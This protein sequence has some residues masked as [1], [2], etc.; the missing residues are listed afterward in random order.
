VVKSRV[1]EEVREVVNAVLL[2]KVEGFL[3][4]RWG[5]GSGFGGVLSACGQRRVIF[6]KVEGLLEVVDQSVK[7]RH[8]GGV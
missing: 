8:F 6:E 1:C 3:V 4:E 7:R 5:S 2:E